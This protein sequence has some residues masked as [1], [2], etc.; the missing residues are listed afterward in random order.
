MFVNF[1]KL[2]QD[3]PLLFHGFEDTLIEKTRDFCV[4]FCF[5]EFAVLFHSVENISIEFFSV[6]IS[7]LSNT[8]PRC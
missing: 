5:E 1:V 2:F 4:L 3:F 8:V 6:I 7:E